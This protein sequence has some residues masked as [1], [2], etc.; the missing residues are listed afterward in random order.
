MKNYYYVKMHGIWRV[1]LYVPKEDVYLLPGDEFD[2]HADDFDEIGERV[3]A[4]EG[5]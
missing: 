3:P 2:H 4:P 5:E 1:A